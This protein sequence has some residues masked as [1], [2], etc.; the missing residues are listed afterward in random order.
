LKDFVAI[1]FETAN[2]QRVSACAFGYARVRDSKVVESNIFLIKPIGGHAAFQ[3]KI[4]GIKDE[5]TRD[6]LDFGDLFPDLKNLFSSHLV[7]YSLFDKQ[8]LAA[9]SNHFNLALEFQYTDSCALAKSTL[10][11]VKPCKLHTVAKHLGLPHFK[12]HDAKEDAIACALVFLSL[13]GA[14]KQEMKSADPTDIAEFRGMVQGILADTVV[15]YKEA[16][17]LLYWLEDHSEIM[18]RHRGLSGSL[19][20]AVQDGVLDLAE[21]GILKRELSAAFSECT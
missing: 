21:A 20:S 9:L 2:P 15:N 18:R 8:V 12:H 4:H 1:D 16:L 10:P 13:L 19:Q 14:V 11:H 7:A 3:S 6:K 17:Q 5:H